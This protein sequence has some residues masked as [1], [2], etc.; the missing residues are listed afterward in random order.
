MSKRT[1]QLLASFVVL[2]GMLLPS[3]AVAAENLLLTMPPI[4][5]GATA[6]LAF[7]FDFSSSSPVVANM[8]TAL[9][10][11]LFNATKDEYGNFDRVESIYAENPS[12]YGCTFYLS[13]SDAINRITCN[14]G[15]TY[16]YKANKNIQNKKLLRPVSKGT[17]SSLIG[18]VEKTFLGQIDVKCDAPQQQPSVSWYVKDSILSLWSDTAPITDVDTSDTP[19]IRYTYAIKAEIP[20]AYEAWKPRCECWRDIFY[21]MLQSSTTFDPSVGFIDKPPSVVDGLWDTITIGLTHLLGSDYDYLKLCSTQKYNEFVE[22]KAGVRKVKVICGDYS[23]AVIEFKPSPAT[24]TA[25]DFEIDCGPCSS[26]P[27]TANYAGHEWQRCDDGNRYKWEEA[28]AYCSNLSLAGHSDWRLPTQSELRSLIVCSNGNGPIG[29]ASTHPFSCA[30][31]NSAPYDS[32]TIDEQFMCS[33]HYHWSSSAFEG[34]AW[35]VDFGN[36][37]AGWG[38]RTVHGY[39]R[40]VR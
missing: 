36:G 33:P 18:V 3:H 2:A 34:G 1:I 39:V 22:E 23:P 15:A 16:N 30:D 13:E 7:I 32:P 35:G 8:Q 28:N 12:G 4:L 10:K 9:S 40:C 17:C 26:G 25:P 21:D 31:G 11:T 5:A 27:Q 19:D 38:Y 29:N 6:K 14:D 20:E 24:P 37:Y